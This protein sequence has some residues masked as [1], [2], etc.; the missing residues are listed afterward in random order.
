MSIPSQAS[1]DVIISNC[2]INLSEWFTV[3]S[4]A[5][6]VPDL[7]PR[8]VPSMKDRITAT[9]HTTGESAWKAKHIGNEAKRTKATAELNGRLRWKSWDEI[10]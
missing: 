6:G 10:Q 4:R 2:V 5:L 7:E 3:R 8:L 1:V 9:L